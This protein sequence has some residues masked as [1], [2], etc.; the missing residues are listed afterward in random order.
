MTFTDV[1]QFR[2]A[3]HRTLSDDGTWLALTAAP[4]RGD[5]E[6]LVHA[7][8]GDAR[9][10][11]PDASHPALTSDGAWVAATLNPTLAEQE[12]AKDESDE[13]KKPKPGLVL[14]ETATGDT[15]QVP[16]VQAFA[17]STDGRW[18][19]IHHHAAPDTS[20]AAEG[21]DG[22]DE[23]GRTPGTRMVLR[24]LETGREIEVPLVRSFAFDEE[25]R[26]LAY[27]V[28]DTTDERTGLYVR[29]LRTDDVPETALD[30]REGGHYTHLT[31]SEADNHLAFLVATEDDEGEPGP[32]ALWLWDGDAGQE[33]ATAEDAPD[34][35]TLPADN[36]VAWSDDGARVFFGVRPEHE[37]DEEKADTDTDTADS[38][39]TAADTTAFDPYDT[40]ALLEDRTVDV[41]HWNDPRIQT[42]QREVWEGEQER[43]YRAVYHRA[44]GAAV[45]LGDPDVRT[46]GT[47]TNADVIL[48]RATKPYYKEITWEGFLYDLYVIDM[49]DGTRTK[50]A[51]RLQGWGSSSPRLAPG[52]RYVVYYDDHAWHLYDVESGATRNLTDD[53]GVPFANEDHD[54]PN[55]PPGY[56]VGGWAE[57]DAAVL[58]YDKYDIWQ[59]PTAGGDPVNLTG[60][61]GREAARI[62]RIVRLDPDQ[63]FFSPGE[64]LLL[65]GYHDRRKTDAFYRATVGESGVR[66]LVEDEK[67][68][69]VVT[70]ADSADVLLYTREDYD[71]F[72]DLWVADLDF[73]DRRKVTNVNPQM[74]EIAWGDAQLIEWRSTD[75]TPLQ[76]VVITP[77][78]YDPDKQY[79]LVVYFYRFFSQRLHDFFQPQ[80]N[81]RPV[82]PLYASDGYVLFLPDVRFEVGRPGF[83]ATKSVVPGVQ[84][85]VDMGMVDPDA[86]G[87]HGHSWSGYQTAFI[88]T[89]TDIFD[90]AI[91]G[92]PVSNMTSAYSGIRW[93]SGLARQFQYEETQSRLGGSLWEARDH[94]IDNS[95]VFF[96]DYITTPLLIIH[97]DADGAVPWYQS[98]ELYLACRRLEKECIF[99][100]YRGEDHHPQTY[101]NKLDW[102]TRMKEYFDHYLKDAPAPEWIEVGVP[103]AG[104]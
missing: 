4:D 55:P 8:R 31:W 63:D 91:A 22:G 43:T 21:E 58:I 54:Y 13:A 59:I 60:G 71:E 79:P 61:Q 12:A 16:R 87:L 69:N 17:L 35:W 14:L 72:P 75:G 99:L 51:E 97:G 77:E 73:D 57:D 1:M 52:G 101:P 64:S 24:E 84:K 50:I 38:D 98:I 94:Y 42:H 15:M 2:A 82:F 65:E 66:L 46:M 86:L 45:P 25:G 95:P 36:D 90:A 85:L 103:Y 56:G 104:E 81:H 27:A 83:S 26:Y 33:V 23:N 7:T 20:E 74:A 19:A 100:Q 9:Y 70:K 18:L 89:Q 29:D 40:E 5:P 92:A 80:V 37:D 62:F 44:T 96:A 32:A 102:A 28:A 53:L 10:V 47:P 48:G 3:Q 39:T 68:F 76:G 11:L 34:G 30:T 67:R 41:W 6:V 93:G 88:V 49:A 78:D